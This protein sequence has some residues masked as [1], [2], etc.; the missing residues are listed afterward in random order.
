LVIKEQSGQ[1]IN[2]TKSVSPQEESPLEENNVIASEELSEEAQLKLEII[3]SLQ[4]PCDRA[5]YG[6]RLR[7]ATQKLGKS[8]RTVQRLVKR[9]EK[10]GLGTLFTGERCDQGNHR[11]DPRLREFILKTYREGNK[12]SKRISRKEVYLRTQGKAR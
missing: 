10:Q 2:S 6:K 9:W 4:E 7:D 8:V 3:Q 12:G 1:L 5:T 11:I